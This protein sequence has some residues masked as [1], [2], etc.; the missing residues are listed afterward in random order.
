MKIKD[1]ILWTLLGLV[2]F[3]LISFIGELGEKQ[4]GPI[5][6]EHWIITNDPLPLP[7][8]SPVPIPVSSSSTTTTISIKKLHDIVSNRMLDILEKQ[9]KGY[10]ENLSTKN[11][12][13]L[14]E[15]FN[16]HAEIFEILYEY[17]DSLKTSSQL[18]KKWKEVVELQK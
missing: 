18:R 10:E 4:V 5:Y 13:Q 17:D 15:S 14:V 16:T 1:V 7:P 11:R 2:F 8:P 6:K 3:I 12:N 9:R